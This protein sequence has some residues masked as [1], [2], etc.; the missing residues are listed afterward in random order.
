MILADSSAWIEYLRGTGS[1]TH[2]GLQAGLKAGALV[3]TDVVLAEVLVGGRDETHVTNLK[4][5]L[6]DSCEWEPVAGTEEWERAAALGRA[7]LRGGESVRRIT[8]CLIA[9]VAIRLGV[10]V[11]HADQDFDVLARHTRLQATRG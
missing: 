7:C 1:Q 11:L 8:D 5:L 6:L 3:T 9:A 4:R 10:P 2:A